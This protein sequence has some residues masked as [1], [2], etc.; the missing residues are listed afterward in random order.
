MEGSTLNHH[1]QN[2]LW[3]EQQVIHLLIQVLEILIFIH[4]QGVIH[5]DITPN[6]LIL[7]KS[8]RKCVLIDFGAIKRIQSSSNKSIVVGTPGYMAPEHQQGVPNDKS[9]IYSLGIIGIQALTRLKPQEI[10]IDPKTHEFVW[11]ERAIASPALIEALSRMVR[12]S[13]TERLSA[14]EALRLLQ[15]IIAASNTKETKVIT[16]QQ[17]QKRRFPWRYLI[18][19]IVIVLAAI[20]STI[21]TPDS[22]VTPSPNESPEERQ[23]DIQG[24]SYAKLEE[25]LA[26]GNWKDAEQETN[27]II[28]QMFGRSDRSLAE[29]EITQIPCR[30]LR[31]IDTLWSQYSNGHFGLRV[32]KEVWESFQGQRNSWERTATVLVVRQDRFEG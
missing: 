29:Q 4:S 15:N 26:N 7:R 28:L 11:R 3:F 21:T 20:P 6:N 31:T 16:P 10:P 12:Y 32:Q 17:N 23:S 2:S 8:D 27:R 18:G 25:L 19:S 22:E 9:D 30:D 5:C 24:I 1:L 14:E 13:Y